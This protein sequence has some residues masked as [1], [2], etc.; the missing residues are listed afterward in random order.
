MRLLGKNMVLKKEKDCAKSAKMRCFLRN[1]RKKTLQDA[2]RA[3]FPRGVVCGDG[4]F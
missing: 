1:E 4:H 3:A 2:R